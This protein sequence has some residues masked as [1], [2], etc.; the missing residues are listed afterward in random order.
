MTTETIQTVQIN[1]DNISL[2][3]N[4]ITDLAKNKKLVINGEIS[5]ILPSSYPSWNKQK[6][7]RKSLAR[8]IVKP[9]M[10]TAN[11]FLHK[12]SKYN[13]QPLVKLEYSEKE[14][15]IKKSREEWKD[16]YKKALE[17]KSK[18]VTEKGSFYKS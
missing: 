3:K 13:A 4:I 5:E 2:A 9:T 16:A 8:V 1:Q 14:K 7:F 11:I 12:L 10:R 15:A 18:Y 17:L 6:E